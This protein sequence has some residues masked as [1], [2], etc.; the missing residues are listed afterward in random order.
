[1]AFP[2]NWGIEGIDQLAGLRLDVN[3]ELGLST[4]RCTGIGIDPC[5]D[6]VAALRQAWRQVG[7]LWHFHGIDNGFYCALLWPALFAALGVRPE[8]VGG[9]VVNEFY[10][11]DGSKF[12]T[13]R[14]HAIW[15]DELLAVENPEIVRLYLA[16]DG[17]HSY[18]SDFTMAGYQA[19]RDRVA[20]LL[21]GTASAGPLPAPLDSA[22]LFR[23]LHAL[24]P[25]S[26]DPALAVRCLLANLGGGQLAGEAELLRRALG[27]TEGR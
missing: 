3:F 16:W 24:R 10:T 6:G 17:P 27:G 22:D 11:L 21:A 5:A 12:S 14:N 9:A 15:A 1:M 13:S 8:Q 4:Y 25:E 26:F 20:P 2:T 18:S 19:F 23:G 7:K